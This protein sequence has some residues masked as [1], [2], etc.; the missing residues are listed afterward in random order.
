MQPNEWEQLFEAWFQTYNGRAVKDNAGD[1]DMSRKHI[2]AILFHLSSS[3]E[4][5]HCPALQ[6]NNHGAFGRR[7]V[8]KDN[9]LHHTKTTKLFQQLLGKS[10]SQFL[11]TC[12]T[13]IY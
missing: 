6:A 8:Q 3:D 13:L 9:T 2:Y 11:I 1:V 12:Q 5:M 10:L 4:H 7:P